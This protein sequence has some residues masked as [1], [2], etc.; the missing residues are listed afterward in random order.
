MQ[1]RTDEKACDSHLIGEE[2]REA[3]AAIKMAEK[4]AQALTAWRIEGTLR[5]F[6]KFAPVN[7]WFDYPAHTADHSGVLQDVQPDGEQPAWKKNF[8]KKKSPEQK[9][10]E[11]KKA[12]ET[13]FEAC[14]IDEIITVKSLAEYMGVSEKTIRRKLKEH[15]NFEIKDGRVTEKNEGQTR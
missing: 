2:A 6:P 11:A 7:L 10:E 8:N 13:A 9:S 1:C 5:E 3:E 12:I 15:G 4:R 14:K